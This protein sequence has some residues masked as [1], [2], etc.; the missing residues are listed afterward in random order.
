MSVILAEILNSTQNTERNY[1]SKEDKLFVT[2][3]K[4]K[5]KN[6]RKSFRERE[7]A[8]GEGRNKQKERGEERDGVREKTIVLIISTSLLAYYLFHRNN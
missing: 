4:K 7:R 1:F 6:F 3:D 8:G 5:K 2:F